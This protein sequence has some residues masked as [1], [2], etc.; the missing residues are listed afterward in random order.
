[1][2]MHI[3]SFDRYSNDGLPDTAWFDVE[4]DGVDR[5]IYI[6]PVGGS[7]E[8]DTDHFPFGYIDLRETDA[9]IAEYFARNPD[10][11]DFL[12]AASEGI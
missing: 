11:S 4:A 1:M 9:L 10:D 5:Q 2:N 6:V 8:I 12:T 3:T 7:Y